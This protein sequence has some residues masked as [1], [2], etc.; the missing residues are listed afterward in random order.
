MVETRSYTVEDTFEIEDLPPLQPRRS[1]PSKFLQFLMN[2]WFMIS[3]IIGVIIGF[4]V[5]FV[6]QKMNISYLAK[7]WLGMAF[8]YTLLNFSLAMPGKLYIRILQLTI[9]PMIIAN[10]ITGKL[11]I[12]SFRK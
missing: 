2:D 11:L 8:I 12:Q 10:I 4:G 1:C 9:L 6:L 3:T 5:G 7:I